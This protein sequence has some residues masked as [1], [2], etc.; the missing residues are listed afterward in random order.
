ME[1]YGDRDFNSKNSIYESFKE[2]KMTE[3][4][5]IINYNE[6]TPANTNSGTKKLVNFY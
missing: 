5:Q 3:V 6:F 1:Q 4:N 2:K